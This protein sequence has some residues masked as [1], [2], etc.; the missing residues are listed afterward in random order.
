MST[1]KSSRKSTSEIYD[2][3]VCDVFH[4]LK[5]ASFAK[6]SDEVKAFIEFCELRTTE[7]HDSFEAFYALSEK[8][9]DEYLSI[10]VKRF[11][12]ARSLVA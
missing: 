4:D 1:K 9:R 12:R 5:E 2:D 7:F 6:A 3:K 10:Q 11:Y 8:A